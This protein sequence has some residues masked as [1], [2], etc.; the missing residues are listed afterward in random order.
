MTMLLDDKVEGKARFR[1][2][3]LAVT[4][5]PSRLDLLDGVCVT[6]KTQAL[7]LPI[8]PSAMND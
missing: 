7:N 1:G 8:T 4:D 2:E 5:D 6:R 3:N